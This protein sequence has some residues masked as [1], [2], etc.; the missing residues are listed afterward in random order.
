M[1]SSYLCILACFFGL[2]VLI[3][4]NKDAIP[5]G[6]DVLQDEDF[7]GAFVDST[8]VIVDYTTLNDDSIRSSYLTYMI[9]SASHNDGSQARA[10]FM[11]RFYF[12]SFA[13][14]LAECTLDSICFVMYERSQFYGDT[15]ALQTIQIF[16]LQE[17]LS[18]D[19]CKAY[20]EDAVLPQNLINTALL[21]GQKTYK[22]V[23]DTSAHFNFK[24]P[25]P[26]A[27]DLFAR[28][29]SI[30]EQPDDDDK[31]DS[32]MKRVD[33]LLI[34]TFKGLYITSAYQN[35]AILNVYPQISIYVSKGSTKYQVDLAPT[36]T[37]YTASST[38]DPSLVYLQAL[39]MFHHIHSAQVQSALNTS[40]VDAYVQGF[41]GLKTRVNLHGLQS[42]Q[43]SSV[44]FNSIKLYV[45]YVYD[46]QQNFAPHTL[47]QLHIFNPEGT[48][49]LT[50]DSYTYDSTYYIYNL[51]WV[52]TYVKNNSFNLDD[53]SF[54]LVMPNNNV[55]GNMITIDAIA[56]QSKLKIIYTK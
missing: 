47:P 5:F 54:E 7:V 15:N 3:S 9:G 30:Y 46:S 29:Q 35:S 43:D 31:L 49:F 44:V 24:F 38:S 11:S 45:P 17:S 52:M 37:P 53:Y 42:W 16:E 1:K 55:Y 28:I 22:P 51:N 21:L 14:P 39:S 19:I 27:A 2:F 25:Q 26:Y 10:D 48:K 34:Q 50:L 32:I 33:S 20:Y 23:F 8:S 13:A 4:C 40:G 56:K 12:T 18:K 6:S 41:A 36:A